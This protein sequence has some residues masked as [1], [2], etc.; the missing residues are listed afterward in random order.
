MFSNPCFG[1]MP[2]DQNCLFN[3]I[4]TGRDYAVPYDGG[5]F[6]SPAL[7]RVRREAVLHAYPNKQPLEQT[8][9]WNHLT[10][11]Y[12]AHEMSRDFELRRHNWEEAQRI[13]FSQL[14]GDVRL[15]ADFENEP[16]DGFLR[17]ELIPILLLRP[18]KVTSINRRP[19]ADFIK[20]QGWAVVKEEAEELPD[21][22]IELRNFCD[23]PA[24]V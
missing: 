8:R 17:R 16:E 23:I 2:H 19:V 15:V 21:N 1:F 20:S 7:P 18:D 14:Q 12:L 22:V 4:T 3:G 5:M 11:G 6:V 9:G 10:Q 13:Y 24:A